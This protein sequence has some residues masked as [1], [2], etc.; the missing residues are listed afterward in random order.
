MSS[1]ISF[2][3]VSYCRW[4]SNRIGNGNAGNAQHDFQP[5]FSDLVVVQGSPS[6]EVTLAKIWLTPFDSTLD[7]LRVLS[8]KGFDQE[9]LVQWNTSTGVLDIR[10]IGGHKLPS[11]SAVVNSVAYKLIM[12]SGGG[13]YSCL[14][15]A[16]RQ[17]TVSVQVFDRFSRS[18]NVV[19]KN[20]VVKT[21]F[22]SI[23]NA[24]M[25]QPTVVISDEEISSSLLFD[26]QVIQ[27]VNGSSFAPPSFGLVTVA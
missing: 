10:S 15:S 3:F 26:G 23:T 17:Q 21:A 16:K 4:G 18:S 12:D 11:W 1:N 9:L 13:V 27:G 24:N 5:I 7:A 25:M 14:D 8:G 19:A 20:I 22:F 6:V 2:P